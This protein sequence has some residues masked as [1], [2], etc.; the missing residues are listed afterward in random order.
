MSIV[1][2]NGPNSDVDSSAARMGIIG[3]LIFENNV[4]VVF[5]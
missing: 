5:C 3:A 2:N 4:P 1:A